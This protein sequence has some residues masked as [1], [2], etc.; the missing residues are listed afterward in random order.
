M[1]FVNDDLFCSQLALSSRRTSALRSSQPL[2]RSGGVCGVWNPKASAPS[3]AHWLSL[4][5][6][7]RISRVQPIPETILNIFVEIQCMRVSKPAKTHLIGGGGN[8]KKHL[9]LLL[10]MLL[11]FWLCPIINREGD[12]WVKLVINANQ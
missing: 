11:L 1:M 5:V 2:R 6:R 9:K 3:A 10:N 8:L 4:V 7:L 12:W